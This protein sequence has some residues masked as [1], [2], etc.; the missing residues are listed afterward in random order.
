MPLTTPALAT[1]TAGE[2]VTAQGWNGI[3][4]G[5]TALYEAVIALGGG[6]LDVTVTT[7]GAAPA[8]LPEALVVAEPLGEGR[9]L[10]ALPPFGPRTSHLLVGLTDGPWRLHVQADG[11]AV[12]TR[13]VTLPA[14]DPV[15]FALTPAGVVVPDLFGVSLQAALDQV[16]A[17]GI[18]A[19]MVLDTTGR[20]VSR[21]AVPPEYRDTP[22]LLQ[23]PATGAVV[24]TGT[25]RVR[26][27]VASALRRDP[28]VTMPSIIGLTLGEAQEVLERVGLH[29]G[30]SS[31][32]DI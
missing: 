8:P 26:L 27:V 31:I 2:P 5:L 6:S 12:S 30:T 13:D 4:T 19:D 15:A 16:R 29:L 22:V 7:A 18:D 1:V 9:P 28:V 24:A 20:E 32:R 23:L 25:G 14:T 21:T 10:R 3:V 11:F 17:L